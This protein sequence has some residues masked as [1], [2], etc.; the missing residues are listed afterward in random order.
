[1]G[2]STSEQVLRTPFAGWNHLFLRE[3]K[4]FLSFP[5]LTEKKKKKESTKITQK[6][7]HKRGVYQHLGVTLKSWLALK[8]W[9]THGEIFCY[10][11]RFLHLW[12]KRQKKPVLAWKM[13]L[14]SEQHAEHPFAG[15]NTQHTCTYLSMFTVQVLWTAM[16]RLSIPRYV[17]VLWADWTNWTY[18]W[19]CFNTPFNG[20]KLDSWFVCRIPKNVAGKID[21]D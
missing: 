5:S 15:Q 17:Q 9:L 19:P 13:I 2:I 4:F 1:M 20:I 16:N 11:L 18:F 3:N 7:M 14:T 10:Y 21:K 12:Q 8:S 6:N